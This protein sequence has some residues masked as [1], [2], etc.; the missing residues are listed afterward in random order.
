MSW[1]DLRSL[2]L[3][4]RSWCDSNAYHELQARLVGPGAEFRPINAGTFNLLNLVAIGEGAMIAM[5]YH[6]EMMVEGVVLRPI[7]EPDAEIPI[8]LAWDSC[9]EDPVAG[10]FVAFMRD[11]ARMLGPSLG[12]AASQTPDPSP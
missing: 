7:D 3:L 9:L 8:V 6:R 2:P 11:R 10:S 5:D 1:R 4:V 12:A